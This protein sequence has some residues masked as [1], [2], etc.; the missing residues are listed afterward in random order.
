[1]IHRETPNFKASL[2]APNPKEV[3]YWIDLKEG[4]DGQIIKTFNGVEWV[5]IN[6]ALNDKQNEEIENLKDRCTNLEET[7]V[8]KTEFNEFVEEAERVHNQLDQDK[9][10]KATTLAGYGITDAYTKNETDSRINTAVADLVDQSPE[11]LDTLNELAAA[12]GDDPNFATTVA[13]QIGQKQD[14]LV[15][16]TNIKTINNESVLGS[17]NITLVTNSQLT[18]GLAG[19]LDIATYTADKATFA[20]KTEIPSVEEFIT[21]TEADGKYQAKGT[22]L[23]S[24]PDEYVTDTE[25]NGKGYITTTAADAKYQPK[26]TYLTAVPTEYITEAE[27]TAKGYETTAHASSTY[28][29]KSEIPDVTSKVTGT[30][31][32]KIEVVETSPSAQEDGV[33]YLVTSTKE[34]WIGTVKLYPNA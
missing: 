14:T 17:G 4:P 5:M 3:T 34:I 25:L 20:L 27:L 18:E 13:T 6:D 19:K 24:V 1:M 29:T 31:I 30:G 7:K 8:D 28:A 33:M 12:L 32:T 21:E 9:A 2:Y 10:D 26:G 11:T 16:G 15:S 22:Y 23:T